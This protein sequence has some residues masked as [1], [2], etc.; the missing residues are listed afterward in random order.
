MRVYMR[1]TACMAGHKDKNVAE[2]WCCQL[3]GDDDYHNIN[4]HTHKGTYSYA[5]TLIWIHSCSC[6]ATLALI[7]S[8]QAQC[9]NEFKYPCNHQC[10]YRLCFSCC[11]CYIIVVISYSWHCW[12]LPLPLLTRRTV[13]CQ[14]TRSHGLFWYTLISAAIKRRQQQPSTN[15]S[16]LIGPP[17]V[18]QRWWPVT[19][20]QFKLFCIFFF[21]FVSSFL[22]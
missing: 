14:I 21:L 1:D 19:L 9:T 2:R 11:C 18:W 12:R 10:F 20:H 6:A 13:K 5:Y 22:L 15:T 16:R 3:D 7:H 4:V 17:L 8:C